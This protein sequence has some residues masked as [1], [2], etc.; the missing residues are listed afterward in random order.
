MF[1]IVMENQIVPVAKVCQSCLLADGNGQ[2][3]C[4]DGKLRCGNMLDKTSLAQADLFECTMGFKIV[5]V[6]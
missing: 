1:M 3:R 6:D 2:P 4:S 5:K